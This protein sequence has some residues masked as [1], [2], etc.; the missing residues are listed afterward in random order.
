MSGRPVVA[1]V[2]DEPELADLFAA[3]LEGRYEVRTVYDG[4]AALG[5]VDGDVDVLL[6]DRL[7]PGTSG[8]EV[9]AALADRGWDGAVAMVTAVA[10]DLD[11]VGME[12]D[13][14]LVKPVYREVLE[15]TVERLL[16]RT[17]YDERVQELFSLA[18]KRATL[19][20][21]KSEAELT[22]SEEYRRLSR[23]IRDLRERVDETATGLDEE[24][25]EL[26]LRGIE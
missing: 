20:A 19:E 8:D 5:V 1:V 14:Y 2:D 22:D 11:I 3:W 7:M 17:S 9:V 6:V 4:Q 25:F 12:F 24:S 10:P 23:A 15:A 18:T 26:A 13:D 16:E 21:R